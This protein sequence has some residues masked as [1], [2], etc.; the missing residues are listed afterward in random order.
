MMRKVFWLIVVLILVCCGPYFII[1]LHWES[2]WRVTKGE[3]WIYHTIS[4]DSII[5]DSYHLDEP[6]RLIVRYSGSSTRPQYL[7]TNLET[8]EMTWVEKEALDLEQMRGVGGFVLYSEKSRSVSNIRTKIIIN[9]PDDL[10]VEKAFN[11]IKIPMPFYR[12]PICILGNCEGVFG[13]LGFPI[14][15]QKIQIRQSNPEVILVE[16]RRIVLGFDGIS[17]HVGLIGDRFLIFPIQT[18]LRHD[19]YVLGPFNLEGDNTKTPE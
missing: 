1:P 15:R 16:F 8:K 7:V 10:E 11:G 17:S 14:G 12:P 4:E 9:A 3:E 18:P 5:Q 6:L 2:H 13:F 19:I